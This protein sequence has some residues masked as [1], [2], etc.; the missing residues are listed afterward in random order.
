MM[1]SPFQ[2]GKLAMGNTFVNRVKEK[3]ELKSN[4]YSGINT[5]LISPR[6]WGKSSLVKEAMNE[7]TEQY[8]N[9]KVCFMDVFT[10]RSQEEFYQV[11]AREV[12]KATSSNWES[13]IANA[14]EYLKALAPRISIG[15]DPMNDF[16]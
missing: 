11:F 14:K 12:I 15:S 4:L 5:M 7:L 8:S 2:Y 9:V 16:S 13:W 1:D 10:I 6:R 3:Q